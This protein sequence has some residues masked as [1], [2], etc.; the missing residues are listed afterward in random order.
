MPPLECL[1]FE[2]LSP[3][4]LL[5]N[6]NYLYK[7]PFRDDF[8]V[9]K[10]YFGSRGGFANLV[11]S[12]ENVLLA[13]QTSY[14]P[15]TRRRIERECLDVWRRHGFRVYETYDDVRVEAPG[16]PDDGYTVFEYRDG[17]KLNAYLADAQV[18]ESERFDTY[19]R[20]LLEWSRRH[21][22]AIAEREPRLVHENGDG[23]HVLVFDDGFHWFDFEM[24]WRSAARVEEQVWHEIVQYVWNIHK[25]IPESLRGRLL[26]ET[27]TSYPDLARL[28]AA[29]LS[30]LEHP[31]LGWRM[32]R[33][34]DRTLRARARKPTSKYNV[35]Q[36]LLDRLAS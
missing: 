3:Y 22:L 28:R 29:C 15:R 26:D 18:P 6:G 10:V 23:K 35:A 2:D 12:A 24:I 14:M 27:V 11:K 17:P 5:R 7:V 31:R 36:Q 19:R 30:F 25:S 33:R 4:L 1:R 9:V 20:F 13:G 16:C 32:A 8:A 21:E 34:L